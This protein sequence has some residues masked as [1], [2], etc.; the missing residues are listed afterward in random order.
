MNKTV[1]LIKDNL[2]MIKKSFAE[3]AKSEVL[4]GVPSDTTIRRDETGMTNAALAYI[5]DNGSPA[6]NIPARPFMRPGMAAAK[7][8]VIRAMKKGLELILDG[9]KDAEVVAL[10][11][12]G[13]IAQAR[14]REYINQGIAPPLADSTLKSR[15]RARQGVKGA[16]A[17]LAS[18]RA[19]NAASTALAKPLINTGQLRNSITYVIRRK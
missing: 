6:R 4:V 14:I 19:G 2:P 7:S 17:E 12:A 5:H 8:E 9:S 1:Q 15:I 13:L 3:L 18:R 11:Q 16:K 10:N